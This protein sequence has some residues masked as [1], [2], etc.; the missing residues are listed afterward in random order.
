[1]FR[2]HHH[3]CAP[4]AYSLT[5]KNKLVN[6]PGG[7]VEKGQKVQVKGRS[8]GCCHDGKGKPF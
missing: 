1:M 3:V 6:T 4:G 7:D 8:S 2:N 5:G